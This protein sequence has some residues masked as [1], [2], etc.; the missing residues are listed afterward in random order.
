M[1]SPKVSSLF[2]I[3]EAVGPCATPLQEASSWILLLISMSTTFSVRIS[4]RSSPS[5]TTE[6]LP[7]FPIQCQT[8]LPRSWSI[9]PMVPPSIGFGWHSSIDSTLAGYWI[10]EVK[11]YSPTT[12]IIVCRRCRRKLHRL[13]CWP[14]FPIPRFTGWKINFSA[15]IIYFLTITGRCET[16]R[17]EVQVCNSQH[18]DREVFD[19]WIWISEWQ[20]QLY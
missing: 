5:P 7:L 17:A 13:I 10:A 16:D 14:S 8:L 9:L 11:T 6:I 19:I 18:V 1:N 20:N 12:M 3:L 2:S 4:M 15:M